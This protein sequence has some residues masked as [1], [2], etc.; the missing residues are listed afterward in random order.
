MGS[1]GVTTGWAQGCLTA[2][3]DH[4]NK[5]EVENSKLKS[6]LTCAKEALDGSDQRRSEIVI[7]AIDA[8]RVL[9]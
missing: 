5:L 6:L 8:S 2:L 1:K 9:K 3:T 4:V 7:K